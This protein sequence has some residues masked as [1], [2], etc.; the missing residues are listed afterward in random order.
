MHWT[1]GT[2]HVMVFTIDNTSRLGKNIFRFG[3]A[4]YVKIGQNYNLRNKIA[5]LEERSELFS[6]VVAEDCD[7]LNPVWM[8][9]LNVWD[10][11]IN[12]KRSTYRVALFAKTTM[13]FKFRVNM[14][15]PN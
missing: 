4:P 13:A 8:E 3:K 2:N 11:K 14:W 1:S 12:I 15:I 7:A 5:E 9:D 10:V 6:L